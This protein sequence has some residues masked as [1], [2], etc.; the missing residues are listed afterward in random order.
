MAES[1]IPLIYYSSASPSFLGS[2]LVRFFFIPHAHTLCTAIDCFTCKKNQF[3]TIQDDS[4]HQSVLSM[5]KRLETS[6]GGTN[7]GTNV[8]HSTKKGGAK[9]MSMRMWEEIGSP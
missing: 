7:L 1:F 6:W 2:E 3:L 4:V 5:S 8:V 9:G